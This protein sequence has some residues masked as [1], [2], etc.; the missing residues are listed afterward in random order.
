MACL[1]AFFFSIGVSSSLFPLC[2][3]RLVSFSHSLLFGEEWQI[4]LQIPTHRI[5]FG[6]PTKC[7]LGKLDLPLSNSYLFCLCVLFFLAS[8]NN[9]LGHEQRQLATASSSFLVSFFISLFF[10]WI[11]TCTLWSG[12][13][14]VD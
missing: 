7:F 4:E 2:Y 5:W 1:S 13:H 12:Y 14:G 10:F 8:Y 6:F 3:F 9:W 11:S